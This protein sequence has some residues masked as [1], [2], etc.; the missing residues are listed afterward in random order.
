[1]MKRYGFLVLWAL[2]FLV[3][4]IWL[5][6]LVVNIS[7]EI[8]RF[9]EQLRDER[10][11]HISRLQ[12]E[13]ER[14]GGSLDLYLAAP[15]DEHRQRAL[16]NTEIFWSRAALLNEGSTG[17]Y[18][19]RVDPELYQK[20][21]TIMAYLEAHQDE[22]YRMSLADAQMLDSQLAQWIDN[23][24]F[25]VFRLYESGYIRAVQRSDNVQATYYQIRDVLILLGT[26][27]TLA[28][29][30]M[31]IA[32]LRTRRL[33]MAAERSRQAQ[34][35]FL[36]R[37]SHEIRTPLNGIIGT[38][39][40]LEQAH[41]KAEY[42][43][44]IDTLHQS[45]DA[46][47]A[48][49]NDV[50][51]YSR[52][53]SGQHQVD[54]TRF[55]LIELVTHSIAVFM[56]Q[57]QTKNLALSFQHAQPDHLWVHGDDAKIRQI[58]LNLVGN[59]IKFTDRGRIRVVLSVEEPDDGQL[60]V[61]LSVNDSGIGI[62]PDQRHRLFK[63]FNQASGPEQRHA[64][65]TGLGLAICRQLAELMGGSME[66]ESQVGRGSEFT[67]CL[68]LERAPVTVKT[69]PVPVVKNPAD[70]ALS[71]RVLVAEDNAINQV[72][73]RRMLEKLGVQSDIANN[74]RQALEMVQQTPYDL[75]LMDVQMP[76]LDGLEVARQL[77]RD[78]IEIPIIALT[79]N[80]TL[81]SRQDCLNAGMVDFLSKPYR[82]RNL[83]NVVSPYLK[84][85][86]ISADP[87]VDE[88]SP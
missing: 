85:A 78:G 64:G 48:Q 21:A 25:G 68:P 81:D 73:A 4:L 28:M 65:G 50:L 10:P 13:M 87:A 83:E 53:E 41:D 15:N 39:Q 52:L 11:W 42:D 63:P 58:L 8:D 5:C 32:L 31:L 19:N 70:H 7:Q 75:I 51:D 55:D 17:E 18:T 16:L 30:A 82:L 45:S 6:A 22:V 72:I 54:I 24:Q 34:S 36:A 2:A 84:D 1:M 56:A 57:A 74:G 20:V 67:L 59:A 71:G 80:A 69:E 38:I 33:R 35:N 46:L 40:L 12:V 14:M 37:M 9:D 26:L 86:T 43:N 44:L 29:L 27:G 79:A 23:F 66:L 49:I 47:L 76:E 60:W 61:R 77:Q 62:P 3:L 88:T